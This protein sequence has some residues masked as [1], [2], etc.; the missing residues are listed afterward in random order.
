MKIQPPRKISRLLPEKILALLWGIA[1]RLGLVRPL[2]QDISQNERIVEYA[3]VLR[4]IES[5][6]SRILDVGCYGTFFPILLA[7]IG[8]EV[9]GIDTHNYKPRHPNF[10]FVRGDIRTAPLPQGYFDVITIISTIEHIGLRDD[11]D[12]ECMKRLRQLLREKGKLILTT[13][14][15][16][17]ALFAGWRVYDMERLSRICDGL[18]IEK[19]EFFKEE[20]GKWAG[21]EEV[22]VRGFA[23]HP[24]ERCRSIVCMAAKKEATI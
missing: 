18:S 16:K 2:L 8:F 14:Y 24:K 17:P 21:A 15:G 1:E 9:W 13:P 6:N 23:M 4:N 11:G 22:E 3:W 19:M 12:I 5:E 20:E 7:S 10:R